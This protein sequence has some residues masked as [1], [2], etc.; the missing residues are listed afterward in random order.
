MNFYSRSIDSLSKRM[1]AKKAGGGE[2]T[3]NVDIN[4]IHY[5]L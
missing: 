3:G 2:Y 5:E 1:A 4:K